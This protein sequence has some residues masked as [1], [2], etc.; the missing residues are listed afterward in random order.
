M[1]ETFKNWIT[2]RCYV[3]SSCRTQ[4]NNKDA[5]ALKVH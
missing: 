1:G 3:M 2:A 4:M 5:I